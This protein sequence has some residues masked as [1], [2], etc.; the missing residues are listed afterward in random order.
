M[1]ELK[2]DSWW[3]VFLKLII[4]QEVGRISKSSG[5]I[6]RRWVG[7]TSCFASHRIPFGRFR[8][9]TLLVAQQLCS[10]YGHHWHHANFN[11][12]QNISISGWWFGTC[13]IFPYIGNNH[14]NW[15]SYFSEGWPNHQPDMFLGEVWSWSCTSILWTEDHGRGPWFKT[16]GLTSAKSFPEAEVS[17][18]Q[19]PC[20][21]RITGNYT[22]QYT[23]CYNN[24][25]GKSLLTNKNYGITEGFWILLERL[26]DSSWE[27]PPARGV[28]WKERVWHQHERIPTR[29]PLNCHG[30]TVQ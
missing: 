14:P 21:W 4:T 19:N 10:I 3:I 24:P 6:L 16:F 23:G 18:V 17:S 22:I 28:H 26:P 7:P 20:W 12:C 25:I 9:L 5:W 1:R 11:C 8:M 15:L 29:G 27:N 30:S 2:R 13:F